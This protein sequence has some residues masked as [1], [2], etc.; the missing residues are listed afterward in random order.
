MFLGSDHAARNDLIVQ[1]TSTALIKQR[2]LKILAVVDEHR[3]EHREQQQ[4][5]RP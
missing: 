4:R 3:Q 2:R 5:E 1:S